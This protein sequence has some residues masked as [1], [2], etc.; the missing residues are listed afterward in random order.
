LPA[1]NGFSDLILT[2]RGD[3][4]RHARWAIGAGEL[5]LAMPVEVEALVT[6][7]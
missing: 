5:P 3:E 4:G 7:A 1:T 6:L 2:H